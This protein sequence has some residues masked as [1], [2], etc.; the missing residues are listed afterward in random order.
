MKAVDFVV[1][2]EDHELYV[3]VKDP[4]QTG[5]T[6]DRR[7]QFAKKRRSDELIADLA[8]KYRDSWIY[9]WSH[10]HDKPVRYVVLLQLS[11]LSDAL[12]LSVADRLK[13]ELPVLGPAG[14]WPRPFVRGA[15]VL[16]IRRWNAF[17]RYGT[18]RRILVPS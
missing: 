1:E 17:G 13:R 9:R 16:D 10:H 7:E 18:V 8:R 11:T 5:A 15:A 2:Y 14:A 6:P 4:D 3:E 12:L